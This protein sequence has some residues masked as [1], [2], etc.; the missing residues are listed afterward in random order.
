MGI[1]L[2]L[3]RAKNVI[4]CKRVPGHRWIG[5]WVGPKARLNVKGM[6]YRSILRFSLE[7]KV[8]S[9]VMQPVV[10]SGQCLSNITS[11]MKV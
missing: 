5:S 6:R 3:S 2:S 11:S 9:L 1:Q 4:V 7:S 10:W 8:G